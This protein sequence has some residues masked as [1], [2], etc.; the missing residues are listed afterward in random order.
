M[1]KKYNKYIPTMCA[2]TVVLVGIVL[3]L[4]VNHPSFIVEYL[5]GVFVTSVTILVM[6][7]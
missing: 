3:S 5:S 6:L 2:F 1:D 7:K 4:L